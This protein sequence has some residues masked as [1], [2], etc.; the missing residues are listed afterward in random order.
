ML[1]SSPGG[2]FSRYTPR[3]DVYDEMVAS[4]GEVRAPWQSFVRGLDHLEAQG[5]QQ[6][7]EQVRRLLR[8]NGVTYNVYGAPQ[9]P[10]RPWELDP[11]PMLVAEAEWQSLA[12][13]LA[14]RVRLLNAILA[15]L[16]GPQQL[17]QRGLLP[18]ELVFGHPGFLLPCHGIAAP[19]NLYL[20]LYAGHLARGAD[21][22]WLVLGD[23]TQGPA[24]TGFTLENRIVL[25]RV[26]PDE[27]HR[28]HVQRL[29]SFFMAL[30][31]TLPTL[32]AAHRDNPRV[33]LLSPGPHSATYFEDSYLARY[34]GYTLVEGGDLTVR[35]MGVH[36]KT[37]GG[38][39]P[40]DV[41]LRRLPDEEC[42]P[43][44]LRADSLYGVAGLVQAARGGNVAVANALGS[45]FL[46]A[47]ALMAFL[48]AICRHLLAEDL[49]L[50]SVPTWWCGR[51]DDWRYVETHFDDL[52]IKPAITYRSHAPVA[53]AH[54]SPQ[55]RGELLEMVRSRRGDYVAQSFVARS[56]VPV[57][58]DG[59]LQ[60]W[61]VLL[62]VFAVAD[63]N[64]DYQVMPGGLSRATPNITSLSDPISAGYL[65]K[66]VWV[67][68]DRPVPAVSLLRPPAAAVELRRSGNDLPSRVADNLFWLGRYVERAEGMVRQLRSAVVRTTSELEPSGL[69]ELML[70]VHAMSENGRWPETPRTDL[71]ASIEALQTEI[72]A[73]VFHPSRSGAFAETLHSL[74]H[75][76]S[77]VRDRISVDTWRIVNQLDLELLF[78]WPKTQTR[79]GD[80]LLLLNQALN[81]LV[82]L[83]GLG[84]ESMTRGPGWRFMDMG[85][86]LERG[87]H[88]LRLLRKTLVQPRTELTALLE[89][90]LEIADSSMTYRYRY[91]TSLQLAPV[92]DLL[93]VDE[94]NPRSVGF[95]LAVLSDHVRHLPGNGS[96][97]RANEESRISIAAHGALRMT[98]VE[99]LAAADEWG[100]RRRLDAFLDQTTIQLW[101]LSHS[102]T[103]TYFTHTGPSQQ[104]GSIP[105][106]I[107][108]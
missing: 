76:A 47:P 60:P 81:L 70:L 89:S 2:L 100:V 57:W 67:L 25:S 82:A 83:S 39:L 11:I 88:T 55:Q 34:L 53:T 50:P 63:R 93:L 101:Q 102:I 19:Q 10:D 91:L 49:R 80:V 69:D 22:R 65:S 24:G 20:H 96:D 77:I 68:S 51:D 99:I 97:P 7:C 4:D 86:R 8:E 52:V 33:V 107:L 59:S 46:E 41:I 108:P 45:G 58:H 14:Q 64:G 98:D 38:L 43:L 35:G 42:D 54:L 29:A 31:E 94:T 28:L 87:L 13:A 9:G 75:T 71:A 27:F 6:R 17:L 104:L 61:H 15:D 95:Q 40:V 84:T 78:P 56:T 1:P 5:L 37:L 72:I 32:A 90:L 66:D 103:N 79:L 85:R 106:A 36:L 92:L 74:H 16:Y 26:L 44:E 30:R 48:P 12:Q 21:G 73:F 23:R 3:A 105:P 62:R 18:P